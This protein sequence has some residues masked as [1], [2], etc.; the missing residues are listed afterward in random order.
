M[1]AQWFPRKAESHLWGGAGLSCA[2][3]LGTD[4]PARCRRG[5]PCCD[6]ARPGTEKGTAAPAPAPKGVSDPAW[7]AAAVLEMPVRAIAPA[8]PRNGQAASSVSPRLTLGTRPLLG[9]EAALVAQAPTPS[10]VT[11]A[12]LWN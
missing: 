1:F 3:E 11:R 5:S 7:R 9:D 4:R 6:T 2:G 10:E 8:A 12:S